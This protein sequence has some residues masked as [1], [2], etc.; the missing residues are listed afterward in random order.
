MGII[1]KFKDFFKSEPEEK[2]KD[3]R[4]LDL[5][6]VKQ[7]FQVLTDSATDIKSEKSTYALYDD[8]K[9]KVGQISRS[10]RGYPCLNLRYIFKD[11]EIEYFE[12]CAK[13]ADKAADI[14]ESETEF[15]VFVTSEE[16]KDWM[17]G[18]WMDDDNIRVYQNPKKEIIGYYI[19]ISI[20]N[21]RIPVMSDIMYKET[22]YYEKDENGIS[23][24]D[25][26]RILKFVEDNL[27]WDFKD[28]DIDYSMYGEYDFNYNKYKGVVIQIF[29]HDNR[30]IYFDLLSE[31]DI[32][33]THRSRTYTT[34]ATDDAKQTLRPI[35][36]KIHQKLN[37]IIK[38]GIKIESDTTCITVE[39]NYL[40][41]EINL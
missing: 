39:F 32:D 23:P 6:Y 5:D 34:T 36:N 17:A 7:H 27:M 33:Y 20:I 22:F 10:L 21:R 15:N 28:G 13:W 3:P 12:K 30:D 11:D 16:I 4:D 19:D 29:K 31:I 9:P 35:I 37:S 38:C 24:E 26:T 41:S 2:P 18:E 1:K 25:N 8:K 40:S 14:F